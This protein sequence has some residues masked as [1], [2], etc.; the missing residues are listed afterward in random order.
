MAK[1]V[2]VRTENNDG[3]F[4]DPRMLRTVDDIGDDESIAEAAATF[5]GLDG[6]A[7]ESFLCRVGDDETT[8]PESERT[9]RWLGG[10]GLGRSLFAFGV[11]DENTDEDNRESFLFSVE[12]E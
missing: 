6:D 3:A 2:I 8:I 5:L 4:E 10:C 12:N 1:L 11:G 9:F 7:V